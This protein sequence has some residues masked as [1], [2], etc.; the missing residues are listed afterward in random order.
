MRR[1]AM[2]L[3]T[4]ALAW[5]T[6]ASAAGNDEEM[7]RLLAL[8]AAPSGVVF[9]IVSSRSDTL[10]WAVPAVRRYAEQLR[11]RF[12]GVPLAV[13]THGR[14]QFALMREKRGEYSAV[15]DEVRLLREQVHV[16]LHVCGTF[17]EM[18]DVAAEDFPEYVDVAAAGPAQIADYQKLGYT[19][20]KLRR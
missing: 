18:N 6:L 7:A 2:T 11:V 19:H 10:T 15:H 1:V 20:I 14:E 16:P 8:D 13:V 12:P 3:V 9:E 17:A 5:G 4:T